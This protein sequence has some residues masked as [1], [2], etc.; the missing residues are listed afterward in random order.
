MDSE[1]D[2]IPETLFRPTK[3]RKFMR[4]RLDDGAGDT[5]LK[6][7]DASEALPS[8]GD[9]RSQQTTSVVRVGRPHS[10]RK[11][12]IGFST[13]SRFGKYEG[14]Q[15]AL[16]LAEKL[17][18]EAKERVQTMRD[19]FTQ[20][21]G[22]TVDVDRHMLEP[23]PPWTVIRAT[24]TNKIRIAYIDSE[25]AKRDHRNPHPETAETN[26]SIIESRGESSVPEREPASLGK[27]HEINLGQEIKL[28]NI[29]RTEAATRRLV[30]DDDSTGIPSQPPSG[31]ADRQRWYNRKRRTSADIERDRLVEEVLRESKLDV[32]DEPEDEPLYDD[33]AADERIAAQFQQDF[34]EEIQSRRRLA[35]S[36]P[37][38]TDKTE[39]PKGPKLGG[40]R[41]ARAAMRE[42]QNKA[43]QK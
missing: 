15:Q 13:T 37:S 2:S 32:Y 35:R 25:M 41:S 40:S 8:E 42:M 33:E 27:L 9:G 30:G 16:S 12:G 21:T 14:H 19:R 38:K 10:T 28:Q 34:M 29:A 5:A 22:Q 24:R 43:G 3:R 39:A 26:H 6:G 20:H 31:P 23:S 4:R 18:Q 11:G 17:E 1:I 7:N 36:R